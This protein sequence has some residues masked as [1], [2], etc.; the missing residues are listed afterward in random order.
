MPKN[1]AKPRQRKGPSAPPLSA[2]PAPFPPEFN[3]LLNAVHASI[4]DP[5]RLPPK[6][7]YP[8][9]IREA[10]T[11]QTADDLEQTML[12][13][14]WGVVQRQ[15]EDYRN[16]FT[17]T[18]EQAADLKTAAPGHADLVDQLYNCNGLLL[19][20]MYE[21]EPILICLKALSSLPRSQ[22]PDQPPDWTHWFL[23]QARL[24]H[25]IPARFNDPE[26]ERPRLET[27]L[28]ELTRQYL[29][30]PARTRFPGWIDLARDLRAEPWQPAN[31]FTGIS[32][33]LGGAADQPIPLSSLILFGK[34]LYRAAAATNCPPETFSFLNDD[35]PDTIIKELTA[36]GVPIAEDCG[37]LSSLTPARLMEIIGQLADP[38]SLHFDPVGGVWNSSPHQ[39]YKLSRQDQAPRVIV[40][41][42]PL[43]SHTSFHPLQTDAPGAPTATDDADHDSDTQDDPRQLP[44]HSFSEAEINLVA[45]YAPSHPLM[46]RFRP[47]G[48]HNQIPLDAVAWHNRTTPRA[49][50]EYLNGQADDWQPPAGLTLCPK[51]AECPTRCAQ[52]QR[53]GTISFP[54]TPDGAPETCL[55]F[56]YHDQ[57]RDTAPEARAAAAK[58]ELLRYHQT[59]QI[60]AKS[61]P[62]PRRRTAP[63]A[64]ERPPEAVS[65][66]DLL[67]SQTEAPEARPTAQAALL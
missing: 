11:L 35:P 12:H 47:P 52:A 64:S 46:E 5:E 3:R 4:F 10:T 16:T 31:L 23:T 28:V 56:H 26:R 41:P 49:V 33:W 61:R 8:L 6:D 21:C 62:E 59:R 45:N 66:A 57:W 60:Q 14:T 37:D 25:W 63:A 43:E 50:A 51:A 20:S 29:D 44:S 22:A 15:T 7:L 30:Q 36:A 40:N 17:L 19:P 65:S 2:D 13:T 58:A 42:K 24:A 32:G 53:D 34:A 54:L 9:R 38:E 55:W 18:P 39:C 67:Q 27:S 48:S 1:Q